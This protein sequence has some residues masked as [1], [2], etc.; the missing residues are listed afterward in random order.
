MDHRPT[1]EHL[2]QALLYPVLFEQEPLDGVERAL[3]MVV[4]AQALDATRAEYLEAVRTA[5]NS[6]GDLSAEFAYFLAVPHSDQTIRRYLAEIERRIEA[7]AT[8]ERR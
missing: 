5:L 1:R 2:L 6:S 3:T 7:D 8:G 4:G